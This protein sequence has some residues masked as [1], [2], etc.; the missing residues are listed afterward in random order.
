MKR[1]HVPVTKPKEQAVACCA[2]KTEAIAIT[3]RKTAREKC[4]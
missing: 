4:C 2:P 1:F 3:P